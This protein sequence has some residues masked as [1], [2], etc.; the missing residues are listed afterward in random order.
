MKWRPIPPQ[1]PAEVVYDEQIGVHRVQVEIGEHAGSTVYRAMQIC[2]MS[3]SLIGLSVRSAEEAL[4]QA[5]RVLGYELD[6]SG[7][8]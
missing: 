1:P 2:G 7:G 3:R 6:K 8:A 4:E 5:A